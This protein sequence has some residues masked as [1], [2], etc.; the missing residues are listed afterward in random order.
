M[1]LFTILLSLTQSSCLISYYSPSSTLSYTGT[2]S[3]CLGAG[4]TPNTLTYDQCTLGG[5]I[6]DDGV[7]YVAQWYYNTTGSTIP[8]SSTPHGAPISATS[9]AGGSGTINYTPSTAAT[10][11]Y[12]YFC[13][14][15][16]ATTGTCTPDY[17]SGTQTINIAPAPPLP[18]GP[19]AVCVGSTVT[20]VPGTTGGSW[21][22]SSIATATVSSGGV[23]TGVSA[24]TATISY[25]SGGCFA[26]RVVTVHPL[27]AAITPVGPVSF[28]Q[29]TSATLSCATSGGVWTSSNPSV[30]T[31]S[32]AGSVTGVAGGTTTITYTL[33]AT[34][35]YITKVVSVIPIPSAIGGL[36]Q[37]CPLGTTTLTNPDIGGTWSSADVS[38]ATIHPVSGVVSGVATGTVTISYT[39]CGSVTTIV[40]VHPSPAAITGPNTVCESGGTTA[41]ASATPG[42]SWSSG[43]PA[44]ASATTTGATTG[45]VTGHV[46]GTANITYTSP[47]GCVTSKVLTVTPHPDVILGSVPVCVG[48]SMMLT[49]T[50]PGGVWSSA[51]LG[52]ATVSPSGMV[53]GMAGGTT[54]ITYDNGCGYA[55]VTVTIN[56]TPDSLAGKDTICLGSFTTLSTP[57]LGGVWSSSNPS[58]ATVLTGSGVITGHAI[59]VADITYTVPGGCRTARRVHVIPAALPITSTTQEVCPGANITL[60]N[61]APGGTWLSINPSVASVGATSGIVTGISPDT[62]R[63]QYTLPGGCQAFATVTVHPLP[64]PIQGV[65]SSYCASDVDTLFTITPGGTWTSLTPA[66]ASIDATTGALT[67]LLGGTVIIRYTLP[68]GCSVTKTF[69]VTANPKPI[70]TYLPATATLYTGDYYETYQWYD[71]SQGLIPG[72]ITDRVAAAYYQYYY[73]VVTDTNG[74]TATSLKY[75]FNEH[76]AINTVAGN[77]PTSIFPNPAANTLFIEAPVRVNVEVTSVDGRKLMAQSNAKQIDISPLANGVYMVSLFNDSGQCI[78][79]HRFVKQQ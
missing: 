10:G 52:I 65:S 50:V 37:V 4:A 67:T 53:L 79:I 75:Y 76:S 9:P 22:S 68:T 13:R 44:I 74:C 72:A 59:G 30:A 19:G 29:A 69:T 60:S 7:P 32:G 77:V 54:T 73:V 33:P 45:L 63:I 35:C 58:V 16:W 66:T 78:G 11:T 48:Q 3:Y 12:Y 8:A 43:S 1:L 64:A 23:I 70:I 27:P 56:P 55:T 28:C 25:G 20:W 6:I 24:G 47:L 51:M 2:T 71:S 36:T 5:G 34:G 46:V 38:I 40:S 17:I 57:T 49:N 31:V 42:G 21:L 26:T 14:F 61:P 18:T 62:A 41:L 15:T 39:G